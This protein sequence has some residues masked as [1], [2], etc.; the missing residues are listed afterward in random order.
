M[1]SVWLL[2]LV[3]WL[4]FENT[5]M[6]QQMPYLN[7]YAW[8]PSLFNPAAQ[9][10]DGQ[11]QIAAI[12][13][14]QFQQLAA[15]VR[16]NT[17]LLQVDLSNLMPERIG[18]A[19][20]ASTDKA[21]LLRQSQM[22]G[23]FTYRLMSSAVWQVALG[24]GIAARSYRY[25]LNANQLSDPADVNLFQGSIHR[26]RFD[27]GPGLRIEHKVRGNSRLALD[28]AATQLFTSELELATDGNEAIYYRPIPHVW[29]NLRY[30]FQQRS[31]AMEPALM[32]CWVRGSMRGAFDLNL[33]A[34]FLPGDRFM[35]GAGL[36]S[37]AS[38]ARMQ[39]GLSFLS[40]FRL[41]ACAELHQT[42]GTT[43]EVGLNVA[44]ARPEARLPRPEAS[45]S[46]V[47]A[48]PLRDEREAV[49][50]LTQAFEVSANFLRQ[51][52]ESLEVILRQAEENPSFSKQAVVADSCMWLLARSE[53]EL[54]Q[55]RQTLSS[56]ALK[57]QQAQG[58]V[59]KMGEEGKGISEETRAVLREIEEQESLLNSQAETFNERH[60][61]LVERCA[62]VRPQR[63][64]AACIRIGDG[65]CVQTLLNYA[66]RQ[67]PGLPA[68]MYP[69]R[70]FAFPGAAA[71]TY[72]FPDDDENYALTS[73]EL[74]LAQHIAQQVQ[75]MQTQGL[76]LENITL[77]TELQEDR[78]TLTYEP[79]IVYDGSLGKESLTYSL[80]D[81]ETAA[82]LT[83]V[84]SLLPDAAL[85]LE[86]LAALK[87]VAWRNFLL[88]QGIPSGRIFLQVRYNHAENTYRQETKIVIKLRS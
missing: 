27:G 29:A 54:Q 45:L 87:L 19:L 21:H 4:L 51:C 39:M 31:W 65:E 44:L 67:T 34:F 70:T 7:Q 80:V 38:S 60:Q 20:Q 3:G 8:M 6:G 1:R 48:N 49:Q 10:Q 88:Q 69:V 5:L 42:L 14:L 63:N 84:L 41:I 47:L 16:P 62:A 9:G 35:I 64:E 46:L 25:N 40:A 12:Y 18:I 75:R 50:V 72:H 2:P 68:G 82:V 33:N 61:R 36:R 58:E 32:A 71:I 81:N 53:A 83:Q 79:G 55:I 77:V 37:D 22:S 23:F 28:A 76:T 26:I 57:R 59:R 56:L 52:Q 66:L 73:A 30:R 17:Y 15:D 11:G 24:V 74:A 78:S 13:R 43:Y 86:T 85:N